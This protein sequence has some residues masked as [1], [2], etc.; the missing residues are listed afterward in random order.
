MPHII[1]NLLVN[2]N[3][4]GKQDVLF[5]R[6]PK[7]I[8]KKLNTITS[9]AAEVNIRPFE[10][11]TLAALEEKL[12]LSYR[13][14]TMLRYFLKA[15]GAGELFGPGCSEKKVREAKR[16]AGNS[17]EYKVGT[18]NVFNNNGN[19]NVTTEVC[20]MAVKCV[21]AALACIVADMDIRGTYRSF[22]FHKSSEFLILIGGDTG[23]RHF[24]FV[25]LSTHQEHA[26]SGDNCNIWFMCEKFK[27][28]YRNLQRALVPET[29]KVIAEF[30]TL[31]AA[32][33]EKPTLRGES[34]I[35]H[36]A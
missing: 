15:Q 8:A 10:A 12:G 2:K 29:A 13:Q 33:K 35:W 25:F 16:V 28:T 3:D 32:H 4:A 18:V 27:E 34:N 23:G 11:S 30:Y 7:H 5:S 22:E 21:D 31:A 19:S 1:D 14:S 26:N 36:C 9:A 20:F 17:I 6:A 24:K